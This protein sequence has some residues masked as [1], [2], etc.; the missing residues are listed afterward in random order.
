VEWTWVG[1]VARWQR[2]IDLETKFQFKG[3]AWDFAIS[4]DF[5]DQK[6]GVPQKEDYTQV[7][8]NGRKCL[9]FKN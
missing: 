5:A 1:D 3:D 8:W 2:G 4:N 7:T 6:Q 9:E